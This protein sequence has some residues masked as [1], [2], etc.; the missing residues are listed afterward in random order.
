MYELIL[1]IFRGEF[2]RVEF[3]KDTEET[4]ELWMGLNTGKDKNAMINPENFAKIQGTL[5]A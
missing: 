5:C 1:S 4:V 3:M 2:N